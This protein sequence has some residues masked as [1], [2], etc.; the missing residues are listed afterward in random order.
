MFVSFYVVK[1]I[2]VIIHY[3]LDKQTPMDL[4]VIKVL[5]E[6]KFSANKDKNER[7]RVSYAKKS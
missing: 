7:F 4:E 6:S 3:D 5:K 1:N 2:F